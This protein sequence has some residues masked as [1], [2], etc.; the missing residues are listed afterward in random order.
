MKFAIALGIFLL[1]SSPLVFAQTTETPTLFG[2]RE[3]IH[4][5]FDSSGILVPGLRS[6]LGVASQ[7]FKSLPSPLRDI[8]ANQKMFVELTLADGGIEEL[9]IV[10]GADEIQSVTRFAP[11]NPTL[12]VS[13]DEM[14]AIEVAVSPNLSD[15]FATAVGQGKIKYKALSSQ[16]TTATLLA[17]IYVTITIIINSLVDLFRVGR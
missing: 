5:A 15:A 4:D 2:A 11:Q 9:G 13:L 7:Q 14:T 10:T 1:F 6:Q 8:F 3:F 17:D 12:Q 16:G